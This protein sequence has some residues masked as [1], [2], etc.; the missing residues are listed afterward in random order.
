MQR[1]P[2]AQHECARLG[3]HAAVRQERAPGDVGVGAR[4]DRRLARAVTGKNMRIDIHHH[5]LPPQYMKEEH[6]RLNFGHNLTA[7][8]LMAWTPRKALDSMDEAGIQTAMASI[9]T[10]GVSAGTM[11]IDCWW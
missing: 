9:S 3:G 2:I 6:D 7:D 4:G 5:F 10:P 1:V 8:Q 11:N